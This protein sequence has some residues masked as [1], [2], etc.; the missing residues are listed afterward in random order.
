MSIRTREAL[1]LLTVRLDALQHRV[2]RL[3]EEKQAPAARKAAPAPT[4]TTTD[5][6]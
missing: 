4:G 2:N 5:K 6:Q 3:E 1:H